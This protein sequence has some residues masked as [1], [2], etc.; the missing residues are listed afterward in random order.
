MTYLIF[1]YVILYSV[2]FQTT[3]MAVKFR[4]GVVVGADS[5]TSTGT[6][7]KY[8]LHICTIFTQ[9]PSHISLIFIS[10]L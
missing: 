2:T 5:R 7:L 3:I 8:S 10:S 4:D 9:F 6:Y 1:V